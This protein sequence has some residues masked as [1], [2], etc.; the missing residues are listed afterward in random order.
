VGIAIGEADHCRKGP[1]LGEHAVPGRLG[2]IGENP[3][4]GDQSGVDLGMKPAKRPE[5]A[6]VFLLIGDD[7]ARKIVE[8]LRFAAKSSSLSRPCWGTAT[9]LQPEP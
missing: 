7:V 1:R 3:E 8:Q 6:G 4:F 9:R 5:F 2:Q